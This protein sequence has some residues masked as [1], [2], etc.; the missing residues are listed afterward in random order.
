MIIKNNTHYFAEYTKLYNA[1]PDPDSFEFE[2]GKRMGFFQRL[3]FEYAFVRK[4][5]GSCFY[6]TLT[7]NDNHI[8]KYLGKNCFSYKDIRYITNGSLSKILK[9]KYGSCLKY[10]CACETG[11]GKG[12]RG[13]GNNPH[14][15]FI[16]FV[17][18]FLDPDG[19][20]IIEGYKKITPQ[21][22][23]DLLYTLWQG[24]PSNVFIPWQLAKFGHVQEGK[25]NGEVLSC[26]AFKYCGKYVV[27]DTEQ[28]NYE[29]WLKDYW[30]KEIKSRDIDNEILLQYYKWLRV[31]DLS[32]TD[33]YKFYKYMKLD[34]FSRWRKTTGYVD[35][36]LET[37]LFDYCG[38]EGQYI[39]FAVTSW[40]HDIY[41]PQYVSEKVS[42][43]RNNYSGKCR[44]SKS[45]GIYGLNFVMMADGQP[46][47]VLN[48]SKGYE[49]Q[50]PCLYYIRKLFYDVK[51]CPVT[52]NPLYFLNQKGID[53]K[54]HSLRSNINTLKNTVNECLSF[55]EINGTY[56][57]SSGADDDRQFNILLDKVK[58]GVR[59][60]T[61]D[62]SD[63]FFISFMFNPLKDEIIRRYCVWHYIYQYRHYSEYIKVSLTDEV[64]EKDYLSDYNLF[65][66][67]NS[68]YLDYDT[69]TVFDLVYK[70]VPQSFS[71]HPAFKPY[72][73][74]FRFLDEL[75]DVVKGIY[76]KVKK[77]NFE[78]SSK[79]QQRLKAYY[80]NMS[81]PYGT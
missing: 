26:E 13:L 7:Y 63:D 52:G 11:E 17:E 22:F 9:R 50:Y 41:C 39:I 51:I 35:R 40:F 67:T 76:S 20:P 12:T 38:A 72:I 27:K 66:H 18:P 59:N 8:P 32:M 73:K 74:Y 53:M 2:S 19:N 81:V 6:Y 30:F 48:T 65:L 15:H 60:I 14:Y 44:M 46:R 31:T 5:N 24:Y 21:H 78:D 80:Y 64:L 79:H 42:E 16:F 71:N 1:F 68:Y 45:L 54:L 23:K 43:Y 33:K 25:Y 3:W 34:E 56:V 4:V 49:V 47:V 75:V 29:D 69:G 62:T 77:Q 28:R 10:F 37:Y 61:L 57:S 36:T 70:S 55:K 58:D